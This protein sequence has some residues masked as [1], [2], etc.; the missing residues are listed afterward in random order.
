L[1][2][3]LKKDWRQN[4]F[5]LLLACLLNCTGIF[6]NRWIMTVQTLVL[7][8]MP[9]DKA[10]GYHPNWVEWA[11]TLMWLW[12]GAIFISLSYRYL[13]IFSQER[14]LNPT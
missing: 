9:F 14:E 5:F 2:I 3:L 7:P 13:P 4:D 12:L 6:M 1:V 8:V 10:V 11:S